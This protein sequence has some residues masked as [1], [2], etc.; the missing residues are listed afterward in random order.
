[1]DY[2]LA[3]QAV[4]ARYLRLTN[5]KRGE[6]GTFR[7]K[8]CSCNGMYGEIHATITDHFFIGRIYN[9]IHSHFCDV[10]SDNL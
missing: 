6:L 5:P 10:L 7:V 2:V 1:V 3:G 9:G 8:L 4:C